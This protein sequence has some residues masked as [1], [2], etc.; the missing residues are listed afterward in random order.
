MGSKSPGL[1]APGAARAKS[2]AVKEERPCTGATNR[3]LAPDRTSGKVAKRQKSDGGE[4]VLSVDWTLPVP[5]PITRRE[6][7]V[8]EQHLRAYIDDILRM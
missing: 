6:L 2:P 8:L 3:N 5:L 7:E 4:K 1:P